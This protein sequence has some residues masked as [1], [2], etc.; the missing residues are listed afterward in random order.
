MTETAFPPPLE[1]KPHSEDGPICMHLDARGGAGSVGEASA[2]IWFDFVAT[3][4]TK[5]IVITG[6]PNGT[7]PDF[8]NPHIAASVEHGVPVFILS[9]NYACDTGPAVSLEAPY[10]SQTAVVEAGATILRDVNMNCTTEVLE[11]I[12][13]GV[14]EGYEGPGLNQLLVDQYGIPEGLIPFVPEK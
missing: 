12:N 8:F 13:R 3:L 14:A 6:T 7:V 4:G 10:D 9:S 2:R 5:A 11:A 1:A